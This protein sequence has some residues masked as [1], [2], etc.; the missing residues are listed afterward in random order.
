[1][2]PGLPGAG[3]GGLFYLL[4]SAALGVRHA[5][6]RMRG[7]TPQARTGEV[8]LLLCMAASIALGIW[9][10]GWFVGLLLTPDALA[11]VQRTPG[12]LASGQVRVENAIQR[13]AVF[14]G[15]LTLAAVLLAVETARLVT[16]R[17]APQQT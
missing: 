4:A 5:W 9:L 2:T 8:L 6:Q 13:A 12:T 17:R 10:A 15:I 16:R 7:T 11:A 1:M 3:I 14:A